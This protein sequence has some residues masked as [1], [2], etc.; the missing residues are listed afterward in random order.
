MNKGSKEET[1]R[2]ILSSRDSGRTEH[3]WRIAFDAQWASGKQK[4]GRSGGR[5]VLRLFY[6][7]KK[8]ARGQ[9]AQF[10]RY[11]RAEGGMKRKQSL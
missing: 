11:F 3:E 9:S 2:S 4:D 5:E 6:G 8:N 10:N 7:S 1:K